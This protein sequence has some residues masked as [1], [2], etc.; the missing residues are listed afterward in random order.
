M[1]TADSKIMLPIISFVTIS[2]EVLEVITVENVH[3]YSNGFFISYNYYL[4][5]AGYR[6]VLDKYAVVNCRG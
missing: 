4:F 2:L 6:Y 1:P 5:G 3:N